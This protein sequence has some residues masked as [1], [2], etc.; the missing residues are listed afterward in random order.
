SPPPPPDAMNVLMVTSSYPKFPGDVTAPFIE[1]IARAVAARGHRVDV[2]LP[3][4]P[5]LKRDQD[6]PVRFFPYRYAPGDRF[7]LWGYAQSLEADV[8]VRRRVYLLAPLVAL[9]LRRALGQRLVASRYDVVHAHWVVP[10][11]AMIADQVRASRTPF[12][13]SLHGSD[14]FLAEK[15]GLAGALAFRAF[16]AAGA[17]TACSSD[18][19]RRALALGALAGRTRTVPYGV[20]LADFS[21]ERSGGSIRERLGVPGGSLL[22]LA[23]GRLVEKKG[24]RYLV[25]AASSIPGIHVVVAGEGDLRGDLTRLAAERQAPVSF[26]GALDR[27]AMAAA[28]AEADIAVVPSVV[29]RAGNLDGLPNALLEALAAG[30]PVV[31]SRLAG[32]PDVVED[33]VNGLLV[34]EKDAG[35]LAA[36]LS[37]LAG[38]PGLRARLGG[39]ARAYAESRLSWAAV[40]AAFEE[41]YAQA[42]ALEPR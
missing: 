31:A 21:P 11:A 40:A 14:V 32:I 19:R 39:A 37:W 28:L 36:A 12:V 22:V 20:D 10:N 34:P 2:L 33:G 27:E 8:R 24:F 29:D 30:R 35:A 6:E 41:C 9:A 15:L 7:N 4:H 18:L 13:V 23:F 17:V 5:E 25:E 42:A 16:A 1:S 3:H 26:P 38:D